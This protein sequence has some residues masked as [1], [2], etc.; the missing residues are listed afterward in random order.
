MQDTI[1]LKVNGLLTR[2]RKTKDSIDNAH[3]LRLEVAECEFLVHNSP[4]SSLSAHLQ[5]L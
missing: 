5:Y 1:L 4:D 2:S 3:W